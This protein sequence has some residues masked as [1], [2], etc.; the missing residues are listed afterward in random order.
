[1]LRQTL[2]IPL[3]P[4]R[5]PPRDEVLLNVEWVSIHLIQPLTRGLGE[6]GL[7][8]HLNRGHLH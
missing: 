3:A 7:A 6:K 8:Q 1:M 5:L 2:K 4:W